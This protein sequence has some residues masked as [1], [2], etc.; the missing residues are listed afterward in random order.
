MKRI[1]EGAAHVQVHTA[2]TVS[3]DMD[4]FYNPVMKLNRDISILLLHCL[5]IKERL[6]SPMAG[7]GVR[8]CRMMIEL[9]TNDVAINDYSEEA[10]VL[11]RKNLSLN[12]LKTA[13]S[14]SEA[15]QFLLASKGFQY[16]DIDPF[17]SPNPFLDAAVKRVQRG[18]ILAITA[19]DT[20]A[21]S[22][23]YPA[24]C[25]RKYW[26]VPLRNHLMHEVGLRILIRKVQ[27]IAAQYDKALTPIYSLSKDHYMRIFFRCQKGR[28]R[29]DAILA[30]HAR[31]SYS[32]KNLR[33]R[34]DA[35][36]T[37]GPVWTGPLWDSSLANKMATLNDSWKYGQP[38]NQKLL[39]IIAQES[40]ID[41]LGFYPL[42]ELR[43]L[44]IRTTKKESLA[45][46]GVVPTHLHPNAV[47]ATIY[48]GS[49][50]GS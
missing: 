27:L 10:C 26:A 2:A 8:E 5:G 14:C 44:G 16:I 42:N 47:R 20:S 19:T 50:V 12:K 41:V 28:S 29:V 24:A 36:G 40:T 9:G 7:A 49:V 15:T 18:G 39:N 4:V 13:V 48:R 32:E 1:Q 22:G 37:I 45:K 34:K 33:L 25:A 31:L 11:I 46:K 43:K 6:C 3:K 38:E 23:T 21:L 35:R 30:H 17:G